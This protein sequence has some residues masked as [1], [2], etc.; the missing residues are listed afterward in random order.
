MVK[1]GCVTRRKAMSAPNIAESVVNMMSNIEEALKCRVELDPRRI[2]V[3]VDGGPMR[4]SGSAS[5]GR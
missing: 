1:D 5:V 3:E 2:T 4:L